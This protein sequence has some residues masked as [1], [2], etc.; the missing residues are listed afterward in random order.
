[1][2]QGKRQ[3]KLTKR[4]TTQQKAKFDGRILANPTNHDA[5][6]FDKQS[7]KETRCSSRKYLL[8]TSIVLQKKKDFYM[9][10]SKSAST[11]P[12]NR[13]ELPFLNKRKTDTRKEQTKTRHQ[14]C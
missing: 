9:V 4:E 14:K 1:M 6:V 11:E 12:S 7:V 13:V 8:N 5:N 3:Q 2:P 10:K